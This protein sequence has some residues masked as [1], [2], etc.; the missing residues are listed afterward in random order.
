MVI[1]GIELERASIIERIKISKIGKFFRNKNRLF[2][3][4]LAIEDLYVVAVNF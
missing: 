1:T 4:C 2:L 3:F